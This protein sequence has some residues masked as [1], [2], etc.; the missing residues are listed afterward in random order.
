MA[1]PAGIGL[2]TPKSTHVHSGD[3]ITMSS[4]ADTNLAVGK[5]FIASIKE[6][7]SLFA[8]GAGIKLFAAKGK[9]DIQA[10]S[11]DID[12]IAEKVLRLLSTTDRIE[13]FAKKEIIIGAGGS[14]IKINGDGITDMTSGQRISYNADFSMPGPK[15]M[16]Y[17]MPTMP[18]EVC[19]ECLKKRAKQRSAFVNKGAQQ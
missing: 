11:G 18:K 12:I 16:P 2:N 6:K 3:Q 9:V 8:Y 1:S 4:G 14:A 19:M 10:Q 7:I 5:S 17:P 15:T 13:I